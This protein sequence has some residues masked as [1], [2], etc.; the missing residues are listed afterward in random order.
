MA[1]FLI[2]KHDEALSRFL[3]FNLETEDR[4]VDWTV[5]GDGAEVGQGQ[6]KPDLVVLDWTLLRIPGGEH[7][8][9]GRNGA[10][11][12]FP[13][14]MI[15]AAGEEARRIRREVQAVLRQTN[16]ELMGTSLRVRGF[17]YA[18]TEEQNFSLDRAGRTQ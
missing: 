10:K 2:V 15:A 6:E 18:F 7:G 17:G 1:R 5:L 11:S 12:G 4:D 16:L 3:Q 13:V 8:R 14:V 9:R